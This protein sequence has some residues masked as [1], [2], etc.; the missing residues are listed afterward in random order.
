MRDDEKLPTND[1]LFA[2]NVTGYAFLPYGKGE[3]TVAR[4]F[5]ISDAIRDAL[6]DISH[7]GDVK[8]QKDIEVRLRALYPGRRVIIYRDMNTKYYMVSLARQTGNHHE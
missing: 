7:D 4:T 3:A 5:E 8:L 6:S 1:P 2:G